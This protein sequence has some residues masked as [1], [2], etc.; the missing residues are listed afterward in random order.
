M[1]YFISGSSKRYTIP[2]EISDLIPGDIHFIRDDRKTL[3]APGKKKYPL[4]EKNSL[5]HA[6]YIRSV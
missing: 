1:L 2:K 5:M 3:G 4:F 6:V